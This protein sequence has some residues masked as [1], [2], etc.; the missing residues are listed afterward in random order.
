MALS[1]SNSDA[2]SHTQTAAPRPANASTNGTKPSPLSEAPKKPRNPFDLFVSENRSLLETANRQL[3]RDGDFDIDKELA[4]KWKELGFD[5]Q[6]HYI[7][8]FE[9]GDFGTQGSRPGSTKKSRGTGDE[10]V[11]MG[12][13]GE[14]EEES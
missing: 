4:V 11:E 14:D 2:F 9:A 3:S 13:E 12:E 7:N 1:P 6:N 10:D 8:R 5:G